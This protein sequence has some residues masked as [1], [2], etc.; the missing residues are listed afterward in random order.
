MRSKKN[1]KILDILKQ[2][3]AILE[4]HFLLSSGLHSDRYVQCALVLQDPRKATELGA[5]LARLVLEKVDWVV[6]PALGGIIIGQE[7]ARA[8]GV[9]AIFA[10][11][12][13]GIM[14]LRRGFE[15]HAG[16]RVLVAEDVLTTGKSTREVMEVVA[17]S[18]GKV[19]AVA[20]LISRGGQALDLGVPRYSLLD[21][22]LAHFSPEGCPFCEKGIPLVKPGSRTHANV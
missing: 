11:R 7:L 17:E 22:P 5:A 9:K 18:G 10:E 1:D 20:S 12:E 15:I 3:G 19:Q 16:E 21:L 2:A 8:L 13:S 6:S 14:T 4:G